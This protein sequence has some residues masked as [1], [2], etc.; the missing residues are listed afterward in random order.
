MGENSNHS[1]EKLF[2]KVWKALYEDG[3][4]DDPSVRMVID[5]MHRIVQIPSLDEEKSFSELQKRTQMTVRHHRILLKRWMKY[6]VAILLPLGCIVASY[7]F[8]NQ[9]NRTNQTYIA[10]VRPKTEV[11][12]TLA[13]GEEVQL[14]RN[15]SGDFCSTDMVNISQDSVDGL[16]YEARDYQNVEIRYN[17]LSVPIAAEYRLKLSDG[18]IVYLNSDSRLRYP[19]VFVETE[20][21]VYLEGEGY[22]EVAKDTERPFK[23]VAKNVE[24]NVLGTHFNVN[25]YPESKHVVTTL[26]EGKVSVNNGIEQQI[27]NPGRQAIASD[28]EMEVRDVDVREYISWKDGLFMFHSMTLEDVMKQ[29]YRWYGMKPV[30]VNEELRREVFTGVINKNIAVEKLFQVIEKVVDVRFVIG[31]DNEVSIYK[32]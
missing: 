27:L 10:Y 5:R 4:A 14:D 26:T 8:W 9:N 2:Y 19:E 22:F 7:C 30:F 17:I 11:T 21:T 16:F 23:V 25:A 3:D 1:K 13:S 15:F 20:R 12:L 31:N 24:V 6:A 29:V 32:K 18:T 28:T